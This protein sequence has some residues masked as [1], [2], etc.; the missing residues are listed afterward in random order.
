MFIL[1]SVA[2]SAHSARFTLILLGSIFLAL[3][4][5][6]LFC[7]RLLMGP[8]RNSNKFGLWRLSPLRLLTEHNLNV[9]DTEGRQAVPASV[10]SLSFVPGCVTCNSDFYCDLFFSD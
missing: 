2:L 10:S 3:A 5:S 7:A 9:S 8:K 4:E 6:A 1:V